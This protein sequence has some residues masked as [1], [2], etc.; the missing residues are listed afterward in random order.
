MWMRCRVFV[1]VC[2][3]GL[4]AY[5]TAMFVCLVALMDMIKTVVQSDDIGTAINSFKEDIAKMERGLPIGV[6]A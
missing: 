2:G 4:N 5:V 6:C 3:Y 1:S